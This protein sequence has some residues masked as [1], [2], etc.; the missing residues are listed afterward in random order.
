MFHSRAPR[1][2]WVERAERTALAE[3]TVVVA[4]K[5]VR[6]GRMVKAARTAWV[7]PTARRDLAMA[8]E[9]ERDSAEARE[10]VRAVEVAAPAQYQMARAL[11]RGARLDRA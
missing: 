7:A 1:A 9:R 3:P 11:P 6:A 8:S 10:T 4:D 2:A 5:M